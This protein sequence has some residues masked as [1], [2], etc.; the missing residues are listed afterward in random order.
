MSALRV[1]DNLNWQQKAVTYSRSSDW[2]HCF[3]KETSYL[4]VLETIHAASH[5]RQTSKVILQPALHIQCR[6]ARIEFRACTYSARR[7]L[8]WI[9]SRLAEF[10]R[11]YHPDDDLLVLQSPALTESAAVASLQ[12]LEA[13]RIFQFGGGAAGESV[14][15]GG[16][17]AADLLARANDDA[18]PST[19]QQAQGQPD[20]EFYLA[21]TWLEVEH[22]RSTAV[23]HTCALAFDAM[24]W[25]EQGYWLT[26]FADRY[27]WALNQK[28]KF[29]THVAPLM[30]E[31]ADDAFHDWVESAR[32]CV[33]DGDIQ[34]LLLSRSFS[35]DCMDPLANY[36]HL[37]SQQTEGYLFYFSSPDC[38][39]YG[40][41]SEVAVEFQSQKR[42]LDVYPRVGVMPCKAIPGSG[43]NTSA[44]LDLAMGVGDKEKAAMR[45]LAELSRTDANATRELVLAR[46]TE[47][48]PFAFRVH[49][50]IPPSLDALGVFESYLKVGSVA[51]IRRINSLPFVRDCIS[52][53]R[54]IYGGTVAVL[55]GAGDMQSCVA[56]QCVV[57]R[58][59][60]ARVCSGVGIDDSSSND[61]GTGIVIGQLEDYWFQMQMS[62]TH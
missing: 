24:D 6:G 48:S 36:L 38:Q 16:Y 52:S 11:L 4:F 45:M 37:G 34:K 50:H 8:G 33:A 47:S 30:A 19:K 9:E 58:D 5:H 42:S 1:P 23:L 35:Y 56:S 32:R 14:L 10:T 28:L 41:S 3:D 49:G 2:L 55:S 51:E 62:A 53:R 61:D 13:L 15:M 7:W 60:T 18:Q 39:A 40:A 26:D 44:W 46:D 43:A 12:N 57:V 29:E 21:E 22:S 20:Y 59:G 31:G 27:E 25:A 54:D 17:F